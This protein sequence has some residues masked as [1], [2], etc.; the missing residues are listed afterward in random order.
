M[1]K[2]VISKEQFNYFV[3]LEQRGIEKKMSNNYLIF[4]PL[5]TKT[6]SFYENNI[7]KFSKIIKYFQMHL[8]ITL[9]K[10]KKQY[11][12]ECTIEIR[13]GFPCKNKTN[14][15]IDCIKNDVNYTIRNVC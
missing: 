12:I 15:S 7:R 6:V 14:T 2:Q 4:V 9:K 11:K 8:K 13:N 5:T 3:Q 10:Y 1:K